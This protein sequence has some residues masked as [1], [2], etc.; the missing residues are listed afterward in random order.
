[1]PEQSR[2]EITKKLI[3]YLQEENND[4]LPLHQQADELA[5]RGQLQPALR[6][7]RASMEIAHRENN[8]QYILGAARFHMAIAYYL[9]E[10]EKEWDRAA[11]L[12]EQAAQCF[13]SKGA[14]RQQGVTLLARAFILETLCDKNLDRWQPAMRAFAE[15]YTVL[16]HVGEHLGEEALDAYGLLGR[17]YVEK[18]LADEAAAKEAATAAAGHLN[19]PPPSNAPTTEST[20]TDGTGKTYT[21]SGSSPSGSA[22]AGRASGNGTGP[23]SNTSAGGAYPSSGVPHE[24]M[25]SGVRSSRASVPSS[26]GNW[27]W[28][29]LVGIIMLGASL[30]VAT[31][32]KI[33]DLVRQD[34]ALA[35]LL[36]A[37]TCVSFIMMLGVT[38][39]LSWMGQFIYRLNVNQVGVMIEAG[40]V[41][42]IETTGWHFLIPFQQELVAVIPKL[43]KPYEK[44]VPD[45]HI[46]PGNGL[47]AYVRATYRIFAADLFWNH[48]L[49]AHKRAEFLGIPR[50]LPPKFVEAELDQQAQALLGRA[51]YKIAENEDVRQQRVAPDTL[52]EE[53]RKILTPEAKDSGIEFQDVNFRI[54]KSFLDS[55]L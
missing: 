17:K 30:V 44:F 43:P 48:V 35:M 1:M 20:K 33:I 10:S 7:C 23:K 24:E 55:D 18:G 19:P 12:C 29:V 42:T 25:R 15:S 34:S 8:D 28:V 47:N 9:A 6:L 37:T 38:V 49:S 4:G 13:K 14:K 39:V 3:G 31:I 2:L 11:E 5:I 22:S 51:M 53:F 50:P 52:R 32:W 21:R 27:R 16:R 36:A 46:E 54:M 45:V 40:R 41:W 26:Y